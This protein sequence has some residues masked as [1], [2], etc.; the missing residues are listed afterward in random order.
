MNT[1]TAEWWQPLSQDITKEDGLLD[2]AILES[3]TIKINNGIGLDEKFKDGFIQA[4]NDGKE[5]LPQGKIVQWWQ[6]DGEKVG[7][8]EYFSKACELSPLFQKAFDSPGIL[9]VSEK[10]EKGDE[11]SFPTKSLFENL[12]DYKDERIQTDPVATQDEKPVETSHY[13]DEE[14]QETLDSLLAELPE[15]FAN[16]IKELGAKYQ[17]SNPELSDVDAK[18]AGALSSMLSEVQDVTGLS[19]EELKDALE[20]YMKDPESPIE[21]GQQVESQQSTQSGWQN[22]ER[23]GTD[24]P[25]RVDNS[26]KTSSKES[27][28][29]GETGNKYGID[30]VISDSVMLS[31]VDRIYENLKERFDKDGDPKKDIEKHMGKAELTARNENWRT[32]ASGILKDTSL[33]SEQKYE[34]LA[35]AYKESFSDLKTHFSE[36]REL[37]RGVW[38][39][40]E[41]MGNDPSKS[42]LQEFKDYMSKPEVKSAFTDAVKEN[43]KDSEAEKKVEAFYDSLEKAVDSGG[44]VEDSISSIRVD[45]DALTKKSD[46]D[47]SN[48]PMVDKDPQKAV[49]LE[50]AEKWETRQEIFSAGGRRNTIGM[51]CN[52][53]K[54]LNEFKAASGDEKAAMVGQ[55]ITAYMGLVNSNIIET[56]I[57]TLIEGIA[58]LIIGADKDNVVGKR[59]CIET[60]DKVSS[61]AKIEIHDIEKEYFSEIS[62]EVTDADEKI[63]QIDKEGQSLRDGDFEARDK[64]LSDK[65]QA[66][67][68]KMK[69]LDNAEKNVDKNDSK[70]MERIANERDK[71][72]ISKQSTAVERANLNVDKAKA[73]RA[74]AITARNDIKTRAFDKE[75]AKLKGEIGDLVSK[76]QRGKD[77]FDKG[78]KKAWGKLDVRGRLDMIAAYVEKNPKAATA[79]YKDVMEKAG[80]KL[81]KDGKVVGVTEGSIVDKE[82]KL[83]QANA[84]VEMAEKNVEARSQEALDA[85]NELHEMRDKVASGEHLETTVGEKNEGQVETDRKDSAAVETT[86]NRDNAT[87]QKESASEKQDGKVSNPDEKGESS[88]TTAEEGAAKQDSAS[89]KAS[90]KAELTKDIKENFEKYAK[91]VERS[92]NDDADV[93]DSKEVQLKV[94]Q[95]SGD[96]KYSQ[97]SETEKAECAKAALDGVQDISKDAHETLTKIYGDKDASESHVTA[98]VQPQAEDAGKKDPESVSQDEIALAASDASSAEQVK[99]HSAEDMNT[100]IDKLSEQIKEFFEDRATSPENGTGNEQIQSEEVTS[101]ITEMANQFGDAATDMV[102]EAFKVAEQKYAEEYPTADAPQAAANE[103][104]AEINNL[105][106]DFANKYEVESRDADSQEARFE[107]GGEEFNA[108]GNGVFSNIHSVTESHGGED[109]IEKTAMEVTQRMTPLVEQTVQEVSAEEPKQNDIDTEK[110]DT[111]E[112]KG[113][114]YNQDPPKV[115]LNAS[116]KI[117]AGEDAPKVTVAGTENSGSEGA[118][119]AGSSL[120]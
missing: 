9:T 36:N 69:A 113:V 61:A 118:V 54:V 67:D 76:L 6:G 43:N 107:M 75:Q 88:Q 62:K 105:G 46:G 49:Y 22:T 80:Y 53:N 26:T 30:G 82:G 27:V 65:E 72:E 31:N 110:K 50:R 108:D 25:S 13:T 64:N 83:S 41:K 60:I 23:F 38:D 58:G 51:F 119:D 48:R 19:S 4:Y 28:A 57:N 109:P 104:K 14:K 71:T 87:K 94:A 56:V 73:E 42:N 85:R 15:K 66:I 1:N 59:D 95:I 70:A 111:G 96:E 47:I 39:R 5:M 32:E 45:Y 44:N 17:E 84:R 3:N 11:G 91:D 10:Q 55:L 106:G 77:G 37:F 78:D 79:E 63:S 34:K 21:I 81:D 90:L 35:E 97:L 7:F 89:D 120:D 116:N 24:E 100:A 101:S 103:L 112:G 74:E 8:K 93:P 18:L 115:E 102:D 68:D 92:T 40:L 2:K 98:G 99:E 33:S 117:D 12:H 86:D 114:E 29:G 52:F 16:E 20:S